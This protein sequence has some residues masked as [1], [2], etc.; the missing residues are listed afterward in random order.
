[1]RLCVRDIKIPNLKVSSANCYYLHICVEKK[2]KVQIK[3]PLRVDDQ[4]IDVNCEVSIRLNPDE[5]EIAL[6]LTCKAS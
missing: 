6:I 5:D 4:R 1:M 3:G 2:R